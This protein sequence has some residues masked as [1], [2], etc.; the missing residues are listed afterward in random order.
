MCVIINPIYSLNTLA[1][2]TYHVG[3]FTSLGD[4]IYTVKMCNFI[5][6]STKSGKLIMLL[7]MHVLC[8]QK[9]VDLCNARY[10]REC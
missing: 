4:Y 10:S 9:T 6:H 7:F 2:N 5:V 8:L 1:T 3:V